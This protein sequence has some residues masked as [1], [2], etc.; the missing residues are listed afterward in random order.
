LVLLITGCSPKAD[1]AAAG[2][3]NS[4]S[5]ESA[6]G[7]GSS[8]DQSAESA[9][10]SIASERTPIP[11]VEIIVEP[12]VVGVSLELF[13]VSTLQ[14]GYMQFGFSSDEEIP[15]GSYSAVVTRADGSVLVYECFTSENWFKVVICNGPPINEGEAV[16]VT[17]GQNSLIQEAF[18]FTGIQQ[19][20]D[21]LGMGVEISNPWEAWDVV[22][23]CAQ[24]TGATGQ[25]PEGC[26]PYMPIAPPQSGCYGFYDCCEK[27]AASEGITGSVDPLTLY[28]QIPLA[29][30]PLSGECQD[31]MNYISAFSGQIELNLTTPYILDS[32]GMSEINSISGTEGMPDLFPSIM[33]L[34][35]ALNAIEELNGVM[36]TTLDGNS[37]PYAM[38]AEFY[39]ISTPDGDTGSSPYFMKAEFYDMSLGGGADFFGYAAPGR[40]KL[41]GQFMPLEGVYDMPVE[42]VYDL[43]VVALNPFGSTV[44]E[45]GG[46]T[47]ALNPFGSTV[48]VG[49]NSLNPFGS[50]IFD[51]GNALNPFGSTV[52]EGTNALNPFGS[53]IF[54][55]S[56]A[57][58][59]FGSTIFGD[60]VITVH[61][62]YLVLAGES[63]SIFY[64]LTAG[65][66]SFAQ[67]S[68][69]NLLSYLQDN[70]NSPL[71]SVGI[72]L[73]MENLTEMMSIE[74]PNPYMLQML[75]GLIIQSMTA[76]TAPETY[77]VEVPEDLYACA[78]AMTWTGDLS[79]PEGL[80]AFYEYRVSWNPDSYYAEECYSEELWEWF[81]DWNRLN[82]QAPMGLEACG[83][84][85]GY[86]GDPN[87][88]EGLMELFQVMYNNP[89]VQNTE[90]CQSEE[91]A[92]YLE[93]A[94]ATITAQLCSAAINNYYDDVVLG[95]IV[96]Y[97]N[98]QDQFWRYL[99][100]ADIWD[101]PEIAE[102]CSKTAIE[103]LREDF[104][105]DY[106]AGVPE[107]YQACAASLGV[108]WNQLG[109]NNFGDRK[110]IVA[111]YNY[112][113][114]KM[115]DDPEGIDPSCLNEE[116]QQAIAD[117]SESILD[118]NNIY[119]V[120]SDVQACAFALGYVYSPYNIDS[121]E[122]W[123]EAFY[124]YYQGKHAKAI[125]QQMDP[126]DWPPEC[127][128][129]QGTVLGDWLKE[130]EAMPQASADSSCT[131]CAVAYDCATMPNSFYCADPPEEEDPFNQ[132]AAQCMQDISW[133]G[134]PQTVQHTANLVTYLTIAS[135]WMQVDTMP[136]SCEAVLGAVSAL[137]P[138]NFNGFLRDILGIWGSN[139]T[140]IWGRDQM[141]ASSWTSQLSFDVPS[142]IP[143]E[144]LVEA[145]NRCA[146]FEEKDYSLTLLGIP[147]GSTALTLYLRMSGGVPGLETLIPEDNNTW[148][149][150]ATLGAAQT[151]NCSF[152]GYANRLYCTFNLPSNYVD[153]IR[154]LEMYVN[155]CSSPFYTN[156]AV[157]IVPGSGSGSNSGSDNNQDACVQPPYPDPQNGC[158]VW[159]EDS[160]EW[161]CIN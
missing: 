38:K 82:D 24:Q 25:T 74:P 62:N 2:D 152:Q 67:V 84:A 104:M 21:N 42:G 32:S 33:S 102:A 46:S 19:V 96:N 124:A 83:S 128:A 113:A 28:K 15:E 79:T 43:S 71:N 130:M 31:Y 29:G 90:A 110:N 116:L 137:S 129:G 44:M 105:E 61:P 49:T 48:I 3:D 136:D 115:T 108:S 101:I 51:A 94:G 13:N 63:S 52:F 151:S 76:V 161:V 99:D 123:E 138:G 158:W 8:G 14:S 72:L 30:S 150:S 23:E 11:T 86:T 112:V 12:E 39:D 69:Q 159:F 141:A 4:P 109:V 55:G 60:N 120:H 10:P 65:Q 7:A 139:G 157:N 97:L 142:P 134:T 75:H 26:G 18:D 154:P 88:P 119:Y 40:V 80:Q 155:D 16:S 6:G 57:L 146:L 103:E 95:D 127:W 100:T 66:T 144:P 122:E 53:T 9:A 81:A 64:V 85:L 153:T 147:S 145:I 59:P 135:P 156:A 93:D 160:C 5:G 70:G 56:N 27:C 41:G 22:D 121:A 50:T 45:G 118:V 36:L 35:T 68:A 107:D 47:N 131:G 149:Y 87:T 34:G 92:G 114:A 132:V 78:E 77:T 148:Q 89:A 37:S 73:A 117:Y 140:S 125:E 20:A 58:N 98:D 17:I 1:T 143:D 126:A 111:F 54:E 91:I 106:W 133:P